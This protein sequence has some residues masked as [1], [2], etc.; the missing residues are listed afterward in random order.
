MTGKV[1]DFPPAS[2]IYVQS[3]PL[4]PGLL[5]DWK[6]MI[7][8]MP[9]GT[10][11]KGG[12]ARKI[13]KVICGKKR[14][15]PD[16]A[17]EMN[18]NGDVDIL[19]AVRAVT[20]EL[21]LNI[22]QQIAGKKCGHLEIMAKDIEVAD[23]LKAYFRHRDVTMN[24]VLVFRTGEHAVNI[25]Y[26]DEAV[27]DIDNSVI[28]PSIHCLHTGYGQVWR[29]DELQRFIVCFNFD[30]CIIRWVKGH[31]LFYE[32]NA[33]TWS[34]YRERGL[35]QRSIFRIFRNFVGDEQAFR[36]CH[37]HLAALGLVAQDSDPNFLWGSA[38]FEV[39]S[40]LAKHGKR[41]TFTEPDAAQIEEWI[42]RKQQEF[43]DWKFDRASKTAMGMQLEPDTEAEVFLP[44]G[45]QNFPA[46]FA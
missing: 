23:D 37:R 39:N 16:F 7:E 34:H 38:I 24:E 32:I 20:P 30:R 19:V 42:A 29:Y 18:G 25:Y 17:A 9:V 35:S 11:L 43:Q 6:D 31:G 14:S 26:T 41:L 36:R 1:Y 10:G 28:R 13:L 44:P 40:R 8:C 33:E 27:A 45:I 4:E 22:R 15:H 46:Y 12:I 3:L 2:P 21:R 5:P